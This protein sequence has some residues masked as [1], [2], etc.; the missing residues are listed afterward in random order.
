MSTPPKAKESVRM[1]TRKSVNEAKNIERESAVDPIKTQGQNL[2]KTMASQQQSITTELT[3]G[4]SAKID[5]IFKEMQKVSELF[6]E[7]DN[8]K[9][10]NQEKDEKIAK[11]EDRLDSLEQYSRM[12][13]VIISGFKPTHTSYARAVAYDQSSEN[14]EYAPDAERVSLEDQVVNF[15]HQKGVDISTDNIS[16]CH[17]LPSRDRQGEKP[18][19][20]RFTSQK[21]KRQKLEF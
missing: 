11:L 18:I 6:K 20:M 12:D 2:T 15:L 14:H 3:P 7:I 13:N 1:R 17:T 21:A 4:D 19:V 16:A 8:L 10:L 9:R 5:F